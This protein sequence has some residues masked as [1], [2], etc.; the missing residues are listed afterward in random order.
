MILGYTL[1]RGL[2]RGIVKELS[3][4]V[5]VLAGFY[6]A[7][8]YHSEIA[9]LL[10]HWMADFPYLNLLSFFT[11]FC[12]VFFMVSILGLIIKYILNIAYLGWLDRLFG[13]VFGMMK[14]VLFVS[15]LFILITT[16]LPHKPEIIKQSQLSPY[17]ARV[18]ETMI[19]FSSDKMKKDFRGKIEEVKKYWKHHK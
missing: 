19:N 17:V 16:F 13:A 5:G 6:A 1:V 9:R 14:G 12:L 15:I 11:I 7:Y 3:A 4:I 8:H 2:F 18:S 10:N